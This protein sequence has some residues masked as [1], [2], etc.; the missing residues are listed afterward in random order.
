MDLLDVNNSKQAA[1]IFASPASSFGADSRHQQQKNSRFGLQ[2]GLQ[3]SG[4]TAVCASHSMPELPT[5]SSASA[6]KAR[7]HKPKA[8]AT[9]F[10]GRGEL[11]RPAPA[12]LRGRPVALRMVPSSLQRERERKQRSVRPYTFVATGATGR[13]HRF[14]SPRLRASPRNTAHLTEE[15]FDPTHV[16]VSYV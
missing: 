16:S 7:V 13:S 5:T 6:L 3:Q 2:Q 15:T 8:D 10:A 12:L 4:P 14:A 11:C 1:R 9:A